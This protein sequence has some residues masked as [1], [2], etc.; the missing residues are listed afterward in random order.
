V[1]QCQPQW[2]AQF[3][4]AGGGAHAAWPGQQ[5][6]IVKDIAQLG[7]VHADRRL[8]KIQTLRRPRDVMLGQQHVQ[9]H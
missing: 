7:Q 5:Q 1:L 3:L 8:R 2:L 4:G 9:R 6:R